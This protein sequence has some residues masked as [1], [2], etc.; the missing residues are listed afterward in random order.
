MPPLP[1]RFIQCHLMETLM[2]LTPKSVFN[3]KRNRV[4]L[5]CHEMFIWYRYALPFYRKESV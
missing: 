1:Y 2:R 4:T 5:I 3:P